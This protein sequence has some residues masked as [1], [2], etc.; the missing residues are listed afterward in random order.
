MTY[1]GITTDG[2]TTWAAA[3]GTGLTALASLPVWSIAINPPNS[4]WLHAGTELGVFTSEDSGA[5]WQ[6][7]TDGP[8]NVP[9]YDLSW[10][11]N[12]LLAA[13]HG[14]GIFSTTYTP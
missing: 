8:A 12:T 11:G 1:K 5:T 2:G 9:V 3:T 6:S 14:R 4:A 10:M 7:V 13:T